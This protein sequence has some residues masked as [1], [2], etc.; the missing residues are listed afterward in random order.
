MIT[1]IKAEDVTYELP[2][3][4]PHKS[5][6]ISIPDHVYMWDYVNEL[7][8]KLSHLHQYCDELEH[9]YMDL[10][11]AF[12]NETAY[13]DLYDELIDEAEYV[14]LTDFPGTHQCCGRF[15]GR[16]RGGR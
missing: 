16:H 9:A 3:N 10:Y 14:K 12:I 5:E 11:D 7:E 8:S 13:M 2:Q 6:D 1:E 15:R 4:T